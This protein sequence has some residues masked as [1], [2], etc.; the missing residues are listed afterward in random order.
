MENTKK[1]AGVS[2][3]KA[4]PKKI[5][6]KSGFNG[7]IVSLLLLSS[8]DVIPVVWII[9]FPFL[10]FFSGIDY[11]ITGSD[12][13]T[14]GGGWIPEPTAVAMMVFVL[15]GTYLG[16]W[17]GALKSRS[18]YFINSLVMATLVICIPIVILLYA[19]TFNSEFLCSVL[20]NRPFSGQ[21]QNKCFMQLAEKR[22]DI[23]ICEKISKYGGQ[24]FNRADDE[25]WHVSCRLKL[26]KNIP[27]EERNLSLCEN[28]VD[29]KSIK[30]CY[31]AVLII[32]KDISICSA[33]EDSQN[34]EICKQEIKSNISY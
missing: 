13:F 20:G 34:Q 33:I 16:L 4:S 12:H 6:L 19:P 5:F 11:Q 23:N 24:D 9:L 18:S 21:P 31:S 3:T 30:D 17:Y 15:C 1:D 22:N 28:I 10:D 27:I 32:K 7:F 25:Y 14:K 29:T 8:W 2:E 26:I